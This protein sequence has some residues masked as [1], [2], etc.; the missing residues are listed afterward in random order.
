MHLHIFKMFLKCLKTMIFNR[1]TFI[2][3]GR[4]GR[5]NNQKSKIR[6]YIISTVNGNQIIL[7][8]LETK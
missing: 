5:V 1:Y 3:I 8:K 2:V 6:C 7:I 4:F